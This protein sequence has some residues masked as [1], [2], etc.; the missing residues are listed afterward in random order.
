[1]RVQ[2]PAFI[3]IELGNYGPTIASQHVA[4][5]VGPSRQAGVYTSLTWMYGDKSGSDG[6]LWDR[7]DLPDNAEVAGS[8]PAS[9]TV[10]SPC[11]SGSLV[12]TD[13]SR[14]RA[15]MTTLASTGSL[16]PR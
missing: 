3:G 1:M 15:V 14:S 7:S 8:I 13:W 10:C 16:V 2:Q 12:T 5:R 6:M 9:P 11:W 4:G